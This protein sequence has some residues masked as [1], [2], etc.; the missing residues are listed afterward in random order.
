MGD[1]NFILSRTEHKGGLFAYYD[2]K[3]VF[4][5]IL[6]KVITYSIL[7]SL[8]P[9]T[10]CNNQSGLARWWARLDRCLVNLEW[11]SI[12]KSYS[13][14]HLS[15][16]FSDH[17]P[18][19]LSSSSLSANK[20]SVF[21]FENF[22]FDFLECHTVVREA[23][24]CSPHGNPMQAFSHLLSHTRFKLN[25][26]RW[27]GVNKVESALIDI[28][29]AIS[30]L[31]FFNSSSSS[32]SL[33]IEHYAKLAALQCRDIKWAQRAR[34]LWTKDGDKNISFFHSFTRIR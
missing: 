30:L 11:A 26:W 23:W 27:L 18:L 32:Q 7:V 20:H 21:R 31:E 28:E 22:W 29:A 14:N 3:A 13:L 25:Q 15:R 16:S 9:F 6:L 1:F 19:L 24:L 8:A 5:S 12:F 34:L 33:L 4:F 2:L 10:W 17:A